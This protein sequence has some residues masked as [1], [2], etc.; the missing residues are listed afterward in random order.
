MTEPVRNSTGWLIFNSLAVLLIVGGILAA[1]IFG[2]S[3]LG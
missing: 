2:L 3:L 1:I